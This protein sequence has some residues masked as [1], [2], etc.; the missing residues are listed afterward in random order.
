MPRV[1]NGFLFPN[2][3]FLIQKRPAVGLDSHKIPLIII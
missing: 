2:A 3:L 1:D